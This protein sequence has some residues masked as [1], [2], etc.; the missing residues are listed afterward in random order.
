MSL[1]FP[2]SARRTPAAQHRTADER[3]DQRQQS[4]ERQE[5]ELAD[6]TAAIAQRE[7]NVYRRERMAAEENESLPTR[8]ER[9]TPP[10]D[11]PRSADATAA[12]I[13]QAAA[14]AAGK[15][16]DTGQPK[17]A[18]ARLIASF[19][20]G[21]RGEENEPKLNQAA[22]MILKADKQRRGEEPLS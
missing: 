11:V 14:M 8:E 5:R 15:T 12:F 16:G 17:D 7:R 22:A 2:R 21:V 19:A 3:L 4:L 10:G 18:T 20:D 9:A 6:R 13:I 1:L